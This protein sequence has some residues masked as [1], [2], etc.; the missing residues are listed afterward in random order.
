MNW[1][2]LAPGSDA[3]GAQ[4]QDSDTCRTLFASLS[5][6]GRLEGR[7][8][9]NKQKR[10]PVLNL[11]FKII[12]FHDNKSSPGMKAAFINPFMRS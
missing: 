11:L 12:H 8:S 3:R 6:G 9:R 10:R 2:V 4:T 7:E 5:L 1:N